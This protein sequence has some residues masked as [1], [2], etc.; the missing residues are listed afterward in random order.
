[1][2]TTSTAPSATRSSLLLLVLAGILLGTGGFLGTLL[3]R[4]T[5][6][7]PTAVAVYRLGI[8]GLL[9]IG[10]LAVARRPLPRTGPAIRRLLAVGVLA[11]ASQACFFLAVS[12]ISVSLATLIAIGCMP[13]LVLAGEHLT[14]R[15]TIDLRSIGLLLLAA[16]GLSVLVGFP[17]VGSS[18]AHLIAG[19]LLALGASATFAALT[20]VCAIPV[21]GLDDTTTIAYGFTTGAALLAPIALATGGLG[22]RP[23]PASVPL[24]LALGIFPTALAYLCYIRGLARVRAVTAAL[25]A[26]LE[27]LT[28]SLLGAAVLGDRLGPVGWAGAAVL[29]LSVVLGTL[30]ER[31]DPRSGSAVNRSRRRAAPRGP[32][33][34][35]NDTPPDAAGSRP[36]AADLD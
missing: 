1:V 33:R 10:V 26:L 17:A 11:S 21:P 31:A 36:P 8:G 23:G 9:L 18:P 25:T 24:L 22:F 5:G 27:P 6:L 12:W 7:A 20:L 2:H 19:V 35:R 16:A 3:A 14:G 32:R 15:R 34:V 29:G 13:A 30:A 4:A 28:G